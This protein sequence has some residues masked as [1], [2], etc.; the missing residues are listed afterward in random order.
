MIPIYSYP[1]HLLNWSPTIPHPPHLLNMSPT[2]PH[3]PHLLNMSPTSPHPRYH[4]SHLEIA[5]QPPMRHH[6]HYLHSLTI[7]PARLRHFQLSGSIHAHVHLSDP[8]TQLPIFRSPDSLPRH[9]L[10]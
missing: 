4:Q 1:P 2:I 9:V 5:L 6:R 10:Q 3:P 8:D 7:H